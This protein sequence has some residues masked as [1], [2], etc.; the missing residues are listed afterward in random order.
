MPRPSSSRIGTAVISVGLFAIMAMANPVWAEDAEFVDPPKPP[1]A[2]GTTLTPSANSA[3]SKAVADTPAPGGKKEPP[4]TAAN[5]GSGPT[6][7]GGPQA[8]KATATTAEPNVDDKVTDGVK[9]P[10]QTAPQTEQPPKTQTVR[11]PEPPTLRVAS[12]GGAYGAAQKIAVFKSLRD[13]FATPLKRIDRPAEGGGDV[14]ADVVEV[15]QLAR[16]KGCADGTF[17][18]IP[19]VALAPGT[20]GEAPV[21]DFVAGGLSPCGVATFA[22]SALFVIDENGFKRRKPSRLADI[23]RPR[24][25]PG[26]RVF[27]ASAPHIVLL[28]ALA[29]GMPADKIHEA[30]STQEGSDA[31]F[32]KLEALRD[33]I[34]WVDS[35][36]DALALLAENKATIAM[37]F[38]GRLFRK[39]IAGR[40]QPLWD[41]HVYDFAAWAVRAD[42]KMPAEAK[43]FIAAATAPRLLAAQARYFPYGPMRRSAVALVG[44]HA[45]VDIELEPYLPTAPERLKTGVAMDAAYWA[46]NTAYFDARLKAFREG[47]KLGVRVPAPERVPTELRKQTELPVRKP[48]DG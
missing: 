41:G 20:G 34:M 16:H 10:T 33:H 23:F 38:S 24:R 44:R 28:T 18:K 2:A 30:L 43:A 31:V 22:W 14:A 9:A 25:F 3:R 13:T 45:R 32:E 42:T 29:A 7:S 8:P 37:T 11:K 4:P 1:V 27:I 15:D 21:E 47:F 12:W 35:S 26:K 17:L 48:V 19:D 39:A 6:G 40:I 36:S 5:G 46:T